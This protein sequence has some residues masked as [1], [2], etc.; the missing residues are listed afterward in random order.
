MNTRQPAPIRDRFFSKIRH[1][2]NGC[3]IWTGGTNDSG[4]GILNI[5]NGKRTKIDRAHRIS[6]RIHFPDQP[7]GDLCVLHQCD[8]P[9]CVNPVHLF[10][11]TRGDNIRDAKMKKR[12]SFGLRSGY[13]Q[14]TEGEIVEAYAM[15]I[16]TN[17]THAVLA[18]RFMVS[19]ATISR[20]LQKFTKSSQ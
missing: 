3:W 1:A 7:I 5:G 9:A 13:R 15:K 2:A 6:W 18:E 17:V 19:H 4:Y 8:V 12:N 10:L 14:L 11:G 16:A 20:A